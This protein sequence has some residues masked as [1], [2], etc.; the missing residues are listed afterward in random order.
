MGAL[1]FIF[2]CQK[3]QARQR[4]N[5]TDMSHDH[6]HISRRKFLGTASCAA[7]GT[8]TFF[9]TLFNLGMANAAASRTAKSAVALGGGDYKAMVCILLAGGN[10]SF[11]MLVPRTGSAYDAYSITRSNQALAQNSLLPLTP[12]VGGQPDLGV[13]PAMPEVQQMFDSGR[14][15][16]VSN[17]G[18]LVQPTTRE[19][20]FS[21][22]VPLPLGLFSHADQIQQW[23]TSVPNSRS[24]FGWGGRM[25]DILQDMNANQNISMSIS[26]SGRNVFQSGNQTAEYTIRPSGTGSIGIDGYDGPDMI[27]QIRTTAVNSLMEEQ[28]TDVFKQT[29]AG[30]VKNAQDAHQQFSSAIGGVNLATTISPSYLSQSMGM[31]AKTIAARET[32]DVCRQTFFITFGG[33][34]HH[35]EL[36]N[37]Q[38]A[39]LGVVSKALGEFNAAM[40][41][42][43]LADK[44]TTFTISDFARTLTSNGNG[45]DHGWG[46][47][48]IVMG[49]GVNGGQIFGQ[50][51]SL[52]LDSILDVGNGVLV[53]TTSTDEYFA[54]LA[55]WFG[56]TNSDLTNIFPNLLN[57]Y[58]PGGTPPIGFMQV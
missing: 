21:E 19:Q 22:S 54:E 29:Y 4:I 38:N 31:V 14:L 5:I 17:V 43:G 44:V 42:L 18:T 57:F 32:L 36:L 47:N 11:N 46:G 3:H 41:E 49:G 1:N 52:A 26:L 30:V 27:D 7:I 13:H 15:S 6:K 23:Q 51:P 55:Q 56:V 28:Y 9:S 2:D 16:F 39:M 48:T 45:T 12:L 33:W 50:Y 20:F 40:N 24:A 34:D 58:T 53:P 8:T 25:A 35:D 10:D 37:N